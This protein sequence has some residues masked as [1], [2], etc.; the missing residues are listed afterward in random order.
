MAITTIIPNNFLRNNKA[1]AYKIPVGAPISFFIPTKDP[2]TA[3]F[4]N[5]R[6][7]MFDGYGAEVIQD[8]GTLQKVDITGGYRLYLDGMTVSSGVVGRLYKF[9]VYDTTDDSILFILNCFQLVSL[10]DA[11]KYA[12]ISYRNSTNI[13]NFNYE[14]LPDFRNRLYVDLNKVGDQGEY[15]LTQYA[16]ATTGF[17]RNQKSQLKDSLVL[18]S[19]M[20]DEN[21]HEA[22]KG[23]SLHDDI[24]INFRQYQVKEGYE[25][26]TNKR[27]RRSIGTIELYDQEKNAINLKG[28]QTG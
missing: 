21:A 6:I 19:Y 9:V 18:E 11:D 3:T 5:L 16:E 8:V 22:M 25:I 1:Y 20:F 23:F 2:L 17:I 28:Q 4:A 7:S 24:E 12:Y 27:S 13:F 26:E 14:E 10:N 15:D